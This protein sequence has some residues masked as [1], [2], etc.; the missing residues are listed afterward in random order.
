[1]AAPAA[2]EP[3]VISPAPPTSIGA[4][5]L[6][7]SSASLNS[8]GTLCAPCPTAAGGAATCVGGTCDIACNVGY[9][10]C[11]SGT[12]KSCKSKTYTFESGT[13]EGWALASGPAGATVVN[14]NARS[15]GGTRALALSYSVDAAGHARASIH[16]DLCT[17]GAT[18]LAGSSLSVWVYIDSATPLPAG[19]DASIYL[20]TGFGSFYPAVAAGADPPLRTWIQ[21]VA[22]I[23]AT[24]PEGQSSTG[25]DIEF[26][27]NGTTAWSGTIYYD[28]FTIT[29]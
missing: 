29:P 14:S 1:M 26:Y 7:A 23:S 16:L 4:G 8:C 5:V 20:Y 11:N 22:P 3:S 6:C 15:H 13:T 18:N 19:S 24:D 25:T 9:V 10:T 17:G 12:A 2:T 27:A 28:D 21:V